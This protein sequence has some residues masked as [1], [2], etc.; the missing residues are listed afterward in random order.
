MRPR[1]G[2][3]ATVTG[4]AADARR[5]ARDGRRSLTPS[6]S[7]SAARRELGQDPQGRPDRRR[8]ASPGSRRAAPAIS[9]LRRR[10]GSARGDF[11]I[12]AKAASSRLDTSSGPAPDVSAMP[13]SWR[14]PNG[15]LGVSRSTASAT[16]PARRAGGRGGA[17]VT[18][19]RRRRLS[20]GALVEASVVARLLGVRLLR[21]Q[22]TVVLTP[23]DVKT[24]M[25][26]RRAARRAA[27]AS[28]PRRSAVPRRGLADAARDIDEGARLLAQARQGT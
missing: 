20:E 13:R 4:I 15:R 23:A 21:L 27:N 18:P 24:S 11:V 9:S 14:S 19:D 16:P 28:L 8:R 25:G 17:D 3:A 10:I 6:A 2:S 26:S 7:P 22:A 5:R 12:L 1:G